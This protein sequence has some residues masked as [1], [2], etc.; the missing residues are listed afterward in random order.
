MYVECLFEVVCLYVVV[1]WVGVEDELVGCIVDC[2]CVGNDLCCCCYLL[3]WYF[4][5]VELIGVVCY[6]VV[7]VDELVGVV[8]EYVVVEFCFLF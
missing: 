4:V 8:V 7:W 5:D 1:G 2:E 6:G 3:Q